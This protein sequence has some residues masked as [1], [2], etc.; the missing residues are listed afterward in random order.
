M[1]GGELVGSLLS[2]LAPVP[3]SPVT[4]REAWLEVRKSSS[5][6]SDLPVVLGLTGS[7]VKLCLQKW[8]DLEPDEPT[9]EMTWGLKLE[10]LIA[11]AFEEKTGRRIVKQQVFAR[12]P[13][14]PWLSCTTDC[15][16]EDG[17]IV[18]LKAIGDNFRLSRQ[19]GE[20][21]DNETLPDSWVAQEQQEMLIL[22][23]P[24]AF[25]GVFGPGLRLRTF[26]L[27]RH[28]AFKSIIVNEV[29]YFWNTYV[30]PRVLPEDFIPQDAQ[31]LVKAFRRQTGEWLALGHDLTNSATKYNDLKKE[32]KRLEDLADVEKAR[33]LAAVGNAA[34]AD[35]PGGWTLNR[36]VIH[37]NHKAKAAH[38]ATQVRFSVKEPK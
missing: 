26:T 23:R 7:R 14:M 36:K 3:V 4:D 10:P 32:I 1:K 12:H 20:S 33:L 35:L 38:T 25:F 31:T 30:V 34:G 9:E 11:E 28:H 21:E 2:E 19:L 27:K 17:D 22:D 8:G 24:V 16:T 6:A 5:G 37:T 29:G 15:L 18:Q 13:E